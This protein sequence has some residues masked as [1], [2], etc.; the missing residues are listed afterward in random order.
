M[1][2]ALKPTI[3]T[4]DFHCVQFTSSCIQDKQHFLLFAL[5]LNEMFLFTAVYNS[6]EA[7]GLG[8]GVSTVY[9]TL[10]KADL[11]SEFTCIVESDAMIN[12][13]ESRIFPDV[14]GE[15][16]QILLSKNSTLSPRIRQKHFTLLTLPWNVF[17]LFLVRPTHIELTGSEEHADQGEEVTLTCIVSGAKPAAN[18]TWQNSSE[19]IQ[20]P[21]DNKF[22]EE[23]SSLGRAIFHKRLP[24]NSYFEIW[25]CNFLTVLVSLSYVT[26]SICRC[27]ER[28]L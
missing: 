3:N 18:V 9:V 26:F 21:V 7:E 15:N 23:V 10:T 1:N 25:H 24:W 16:N 20:L 17:L 27:Y 2:F 4:I 19:P 11:L 5:I 12:P 14:Q 6:E 8:T 28:P 22:Q 13:I